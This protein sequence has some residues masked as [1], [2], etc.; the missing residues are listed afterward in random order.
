MRRLHNGELNDLYS[1]SSIIRMIRSRRMR[2]VRHVARMRKKC[3][4]GFGGEPQGQ[5]TTCKT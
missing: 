5:E 2:F 3:L 4:E 1:T